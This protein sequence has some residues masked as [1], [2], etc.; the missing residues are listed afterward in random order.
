MNPKALDKI[1]AVS[2]DCMKKQL[3]ISEEELEIVKTCNIILHIAA[4]VRFDDALQKAILMN[5]RGTAEVCELAL[6]IPNL[7][8]VVHV[9]TGYCNPNHNTIHEFVYPHNTSWK[10]YVQFAETIDEDTLDILTPKYSF[11]L[12]VN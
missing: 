12:F 7:R 4:S 5:T 3:G 10:Q 2:G 11:Y 8:S 6:K 1:H 9:S